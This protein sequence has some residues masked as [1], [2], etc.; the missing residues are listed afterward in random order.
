LPKDE[1]IQ[2]IYGGPK[3]ADC[4]IARFSRLYDVLNKTVVHASMVPYDT[5]ERELAASHLYETTERDL[6]LYDRGYAAF[7]LFA[8]KRKGSSLGK[9]RAG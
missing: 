1:E 6:M 5:G 3:D 4:P 9:E 2:A 7:W 8:R